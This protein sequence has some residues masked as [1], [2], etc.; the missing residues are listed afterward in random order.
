MSKSCQF[1]GYA[2]TKN[3]V[4]TPCQ[5]PAVYVMRLRGVY[6]LVMGKRRVCEGHREFLMNPAVRAAGRDWVIDHRIG[7]ARLSKK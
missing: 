1:C 6:A 5:K 4:T 3:G 7:D 2:N